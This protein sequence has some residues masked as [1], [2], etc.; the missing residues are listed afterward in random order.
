MKKALINNNIVIQVEENDFPVAVPLEWVDCPDECQP[1]WK[2]HNNRLVE[3]TSD[4]INTMGKDNAEEVTHSITICRDQK[5]FGGILVDKVSVQ[6]DDL[7][8]QRLMAARI[9]AKE[10]PHYVVNWKS[11]NGFVILTSP[12]I[13]DLADKVRVHVQRCFDVEKYSIS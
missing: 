10:D 9:I 7:S 3:Y 12:M 1:G 13:I 5:L 11:E 4:E 6:T 8:Q 2:I